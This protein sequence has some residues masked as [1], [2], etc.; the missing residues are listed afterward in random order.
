MNRRSPGFSLSKAIA[1][2]LQHKAA[3]AL[4]PTTLD[5]YE[6]ILQQW[7]DHVG[8]VEVGQITTQDFRAYLA[9][10]RT[11]RHTESCVKSQKR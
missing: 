11:G 4:S 2:F 10:L 9:W 7:L 6:R 1:G 8:D 3:E 5:S